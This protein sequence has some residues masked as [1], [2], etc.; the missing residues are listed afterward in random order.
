MSPPLAALVL[1][2]ESVC[3]TVLGVI[4]LGDTFTRHQIGGCAF[5][6]AAV[7]MTQLCQLFPARG[8]GKTDDRLCC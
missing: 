7:V 4:F 1:A 3:A 2:Q 8:Q 6:F 5:V